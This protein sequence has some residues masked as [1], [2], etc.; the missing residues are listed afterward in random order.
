MKPQLPEFAA[1]TFDCYGTLIDWERGLLT[2][3]RPWAE[4]ESINASEDQLLEAFAAAES[5]AEAAAPGGLYSDILVDV[6]QR[7]ARAFRVAPSKGDA[8]ALARS[9]GDWPAFPDTLGALQRLKALCKLAVVSNVDHASFA[10]TRP[11][12]GV[13]LDALV[14]AEDVGS[15]KPAHGHFLRAFEALAAV[16]VER[17]RILHVAQSLWHDHAPAKA[18]G[19]TTVWIDRR[20]G[21]AGGGATPPPPEGVTP[22]FTFGSMEEFADAVVAA[23]ASLG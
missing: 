19:M 22:D 14:T 16:G 15:Y 9:V 17:R 21:R 12:L 1:L 18:L 13:A 8:E 3:L 20:R 4:R 10:R 5:A 23:F 6:H 2:V 7:L 11:K